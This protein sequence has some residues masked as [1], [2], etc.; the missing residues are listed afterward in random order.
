MNIL[1]TLNANY[2]GPLTTMLTSLFLNNP[3]EHFT[4]Y[5]M[6]SSIDEGA[7]ERLGAYVGRHGSELQIIRVD[8]GEF[9]DA[10]VLMH[11]TK[12]MYYRL[13]AHRFLPPDVDRILYLDPDILVLNAVRPLYETDL[14]GYLYAACY[15]DKFSVK[16]IN[17]IRLMPYDIDYYYNSGVLLMN[18]ELQREQI[19]EDIIYQFVEKNRSRLVMPDQDILNALYSKKIKPLDET[20]YNYDARFYLYYKFKSNGQCDMDYVINR[21]VILH[22]C[23]KKKPWSRSYSGKFHALYK[24]Y[25]RLTQLGLQAAELPQAIIAPA[26]APAASPRAS[27]ALD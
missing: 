19:K 6:H 1:V 18:L 3:G 24:H 27:T 15:H 23:G 25:E 5:L 7:L 11:Y 10:P 20:L 2:L 22:F 16:E 14:D 4:I 12:E 26:E 13:L 17:R 9:E 21:T 8:E